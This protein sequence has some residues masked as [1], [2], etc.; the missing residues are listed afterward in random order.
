MREAVIVEA[1]RTP[2]ARGKLGRGGLSGM[3]PVRLLA[4]MQQAVVERAG[5]PAK[6]VEQVIGGC[7]TQAGEQAG[8]L[9]RNAWLTRGDGWHTG[10]TTIDTQCGSG[11]QANHLISALIRSG[12]IDAGIGCGVGWREVVFAWIGPDL[13]SAG[14]SPVAGCCVL[15]CPA[16]EVPDGADGD[17]EAGDGAA[18]AG[19]EVAGAAGDAC[20]VCERWNFSRTGHQD[21]STEVLSATNC[22]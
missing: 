13:A 22:S 17:D 1:L 11:Q 6:D 10:A 5:I 8:N 7:V 16:G 15:D 3:H 21:S 14:A 20:P 12:N 19:V 9:A 18:V 2:I 4:R